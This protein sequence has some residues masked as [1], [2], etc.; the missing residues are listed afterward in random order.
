MDIKKR[1]KEFNM[2]SSYFAQKL[3]ISRPTLSNYIE[4]YQ[5]G[6][7]LPR[8]KY[9]IMFMELF[10]DGV[11]TEEEFR[12]LLENFHNLIERDKS[13]G[14][15]DYGAESTDLMTLIFS[16][17]KTDF[18]SK[19][20]DEGVYIF[21]NT[22]INS[23]RREP[24]LMKFIDYIL[25]LNGHSVVE[26]ITNDQKIFLSN[27]YKFFLDAKNNTLEFNEEYFNK[28][29]KRVN[30][31]KINQANK[32]ENI[33]EQIK[34]KIGEE[35]DKKLKMGLEIQDIDM[36]DLMKNLKLDEK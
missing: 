6:N 1:L 35:I 36:E 21:I 3:E 34:Q 8:E 14:T 15:F 27:L 28:F 5:N 2:T 9:Q 10:A 12:E 17:M 26:D 11:E 7:K 19:D 23:Y 24:I 32:E 16:R 30:S 33:K 13:Y 4:A 20:F 22:L 29:L 31:I 18:K 25:L